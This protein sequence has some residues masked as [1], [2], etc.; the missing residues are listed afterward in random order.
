M[1][2]KKE[3]FEVGLKPG[4]RARS[5]TT[6]IQR[7]LAIANRVASELKQDLGTNLRA[8]GL[9]G[10]VARGTAQKYS[11]IDFLIIVRKRR[12]PKDH[13]RRFKIVDDTYCSLGFETWESAVSQITTPSYELPEI[14]GGFTK[15]MSLFDPERLFPKLERLANGVPPA[16]FLKSAERALNH[17]YEDF[18]RVKN[19][20]LNND[21]FVLHDNLFYTTHSAALTVAAPNHAHSVS[22]REIFKA[23]RHF[24][25]LPTGY[26]RIKQLRYGS[27]K[28][29]ALIKTFLAFYCDVVAFATERGVRFPLSLQLLREL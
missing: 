23:H 26:R 11:D 4:P 3:D 9:Q 17:S 25:D 5:D 16:T 29:R 22:D 7:K 19:A 2:G 24:S 28:G 14:L 6:I 15:N 18:C 27:L 13:V 8:V 1:Q 20:H 21:Q 12:E 10:S